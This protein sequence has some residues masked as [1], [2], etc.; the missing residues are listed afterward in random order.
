MRKH[1]CLF[2][3][4]TVGDVNHISPGFA[5]ET[6]RLY[7]VLE[8][9][10]QNRDWLTGPGRGVYSLADINCVPWLRIHSYAGIDTLDVWPRVKASR[11][12]LNPPLSLSC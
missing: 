7:G 6:K 11:F 5:D 9:H 3:P 4:D 1:V 8:S 2:A 12:V 10:L